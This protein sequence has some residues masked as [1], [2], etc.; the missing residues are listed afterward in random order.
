MS[1]KGTD[2]NPASTNMKEIAHIAFCKLAIC[3]CYLLISP[4]ALQVADNVY[5]C[6]D[7]LFTNGLEAGSLFCLGELELQW[8]LTFGWRCMD[9]KRLHSRGDLQNDSKTTKIMACNY[10]H[11]SLT[12]SSKQ[13]AEYPRNINSSFYWL[14]AIITPGQNS[15]SL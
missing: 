3:R 11:C 6:L 10:F 8:A 12:A 5:I 4:S 9:G 7:N 1:G 2:D 15:L 14:S 13:L